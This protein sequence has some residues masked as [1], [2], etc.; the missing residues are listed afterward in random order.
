[1]KEQHAKPGRGAERT[2]RRAKHNLFKFY[3]SSFYCLS[4]PTSLTS[5][6]GKG[7]N[8]SKDE[9]QSCTASAAVLKHSEMGSN[10]STM[11]R[12]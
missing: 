11:T 7:Q 5:P 12:H 6:V 1:M 4:R 3:N 9:D 8:S 10:P 2:G